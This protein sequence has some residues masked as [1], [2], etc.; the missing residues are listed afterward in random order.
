MVLY[1]LYGSYSFYDFY[2]L[3]IPYQQIMN[4]IAI[5]IDVGISTTKIV[6]ICDGEVI[7]PLWIKATDPVTSLYGAFGKFLHDN[8]IA[9]DDVER[10]MLT[11]VGSLSAP[12][13]IHGLPTQ[14]VSE[15]VCDGLGARYLSGI[16]RMV[17]V[18][19]GT[20][21]T[22]VRVDGDT[23]TH[24]GGLAMGGGTLNGLSRLLLPHL[25]L[26]E[27]VALSREGDQRKV[28]LLIGDVCPV[29]L[30]NLPTYTTASL[31][32]KI[33]R[34]EASESD[35]ARALTWMVL[36]TIGSGAVLSQSHEGG[37]RDFV[38]IGA[39]T[40]LPVSDALFAMM[41]QL[42]GVRFHTPRHATYCTALGAALA[43]ER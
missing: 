9:L 3:Y 43:A 35:L 15:F 30:E 31:F 21:T 14:C 38:L 2:N 32:G 5:G 4:K 36:E 18:S 25:S 23:M 33:G 40:Q 6:G 11:G 27:V 17:V 16:D 22:L 10:V 42:Y 26:D 41:E 37:L 12:A 7:S 8:D 28:N 24:I 29:A 34:G 1:S 13:S 20:G 39:L 19:M